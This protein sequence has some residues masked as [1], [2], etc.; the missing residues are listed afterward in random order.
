VLRQ[1]QVYVRIDCLYVH[2]HGGCIWLRWQG[3]LGVQLQRL[4]SRE[5][6]DVLTALAVAQ[7]GKVD[8]RWVVVF[9]QLLLHVVTNQDQVFVPTGCL[10]MYLHGICMWLRW[11]GCLGVQLQRLRSREVADVLTALAVAR[12][13]KVD[14][15]WVVVLYGQLSLLPAVSQQVYADLHAVCLCV[16]LHGIVIWLH[17]FAL[18]GLPW[19]AAAAAAVMGGGRR[20]DSTGC[21]TLR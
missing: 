19:G 7:C 5:V 21:S 10:Y 18:A 9:G 15:R 11:Q 14:P 8:P 16:F 2:L 3:C 13:G 1:D 20:A 12:C 17:L 4:R 6:A